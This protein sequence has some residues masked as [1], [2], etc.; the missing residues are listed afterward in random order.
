LVAFQWTIDEKPSKGKVKKNDTKKPPKKPA[1]E[2]GE[3]G[4]SSSESSDGME[5]IFTNT[6]IGVYNIYLRK[7]QAYLE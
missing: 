5:N 3:T 4:D 1:S 7:L 6:S 2:S